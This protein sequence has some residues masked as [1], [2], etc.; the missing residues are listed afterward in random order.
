MRANVMMATLPADLQAGDQVHLGTQAAVRLEMD[1]GRTRIWADGDT[2]LIISS[3]RESRD[4]DG[5][6]LDI[7]QGKLLIEAA[8]QPADAPLRIRSPRSEA[9]VIGTVLSFAAMPDHDRLQVGH[10][11]VAYSRLAG[12]QRSHITVGGFGESD[13]LR[14]TVG[15]LNYQP[16]PAVTKA[17]IS[18]FALIDDTTDMPIPG[19][20]QLTSGCVIDM[21][22]L[23]GRKINIRAE[24]SWP[25]VNEQQGHVVF[26]YD[27]HEPIA[28]GGAPY[29][30]LSDAPPL[31][32]TI[33]P[34]RFA[35]GIHALVATPYSEK[36]ANHP[37]NQRPHGGNGSPGQSA[38]LIFTVINALP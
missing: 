4:R 36:L 38:T 35:N 7:T 21:A 3:I 22:E 20:A 31:S 14:L 6:R 12:D 28:E 11:V 5:T 33:P 27:T 24:V 30:V 34:E 25:S 17:T 2:T 9:E 1:H 19:Y 16:P 29:T 15:R 26:H 37:L 13:G 18:R 32:T 23:N 8:P 10:G